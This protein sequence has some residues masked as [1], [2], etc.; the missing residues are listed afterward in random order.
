MSKHGDINMIISG[1]GGNAN[2][3]IPT[4][5][6][7]TSSPSSSPSSSSSSSRQN[8]QTSQTNKQDVERGR[9][10]VRSGPE[11]KRG[12]SVTPTMLLF[13]PTVGRQSGDKEGA[14]EREGE[15]KKKKK[16]QTKAL[17]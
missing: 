8:K 4:R 7:A 11:K 14:R 16:E 12:E 10:P 2:R 15:K 17:V 6:E 3:R 5:P 13:L 1:S 9:L